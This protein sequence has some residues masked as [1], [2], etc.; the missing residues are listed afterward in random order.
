MNRP[1]YHLELEPVAGNYL[2][3]P[4][5]RL[6]RLLKAMLRAYGWRCTRCVPLAPANEEQAPTSG[7]P[8][9]SRRA[10]ATAHLRGGSQTSKAG[11]AEQGS[12]VAFPFRDW[13]QK[14]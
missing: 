7:G 11:R 3:P 4:E 1:R 9:M 10:R 5:K 13:H 14:F 2:A 6:A 12:N 8:A